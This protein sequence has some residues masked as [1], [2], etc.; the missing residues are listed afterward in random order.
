MSQM[1]DGSAKILSHT[2]KLAVHRRTELSPPV[3]V[4]FDLTNIC[5]HRCP[6]CVGGRDNTATLSLAKALQVVAELSEYGVKGLVF[7]GG[8]DPLVHRE[9]V[10]IIEHAARLCLE[11]GLIT[12]GQAIAADKDKA[13]LLV[14]AC[15][16]IRVSIDAG[17]PET[18]RHVHGVDRFNDAWA[19]VRHL[20]NAAVE[21]AQWPTIGVGYLIGFE[22][23]D[24]MVRATQL[25]RDAGAAYIQFRPFVE[26][27]TEAFDL[28]TVLATCRAFE[29]ETFRVGYVQHKYDG[30][31]RLMRQYSR[32]H[33]CYFTSVIQADGNVVL[34]CLHRGNPQFYGGSI[35]EKPFREIWEGDALARLRQIDPTK[36]PP[37]CRHDTLNEFVDLCMQPK[38]H[39]NFL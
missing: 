12:N 7:T 10:E 14:G 13:T 1:F 8:G 31:R 4:E 16:W 11:V 20:A 33:G 17:D 23:V 26:E 3:T 37:L 30:P 5:Q 27:A 32:C 34:C 9:A 39:E 29:T 25:A 24:G 38:D 2:D 22:T 18:Y 6:R 35:H 19:A 15:R 28:T 36:C 21:C